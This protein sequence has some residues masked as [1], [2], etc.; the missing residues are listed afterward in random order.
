MDKYHTLMLIIFT[1]VHI[2]VATASTDLS[3][4]DIHRVGDD[5]SISVMNNGSNT[6]ARLTVYAVAE[7]NALVESLHPYPAE[8]VYHCNETWNITHPG[9][10]R[11]R[12]HFSEIEVY[13][14]AGERDRLII[15]DGDHGLVCAYPPM[16]IRLGPYKPYHASDV[17][18]PWIAGDMVRVVLNITGDR[19]QFKTYGFHIDEYD[20]YE[21][22]VPIYDEDID[23]G[24]HESKNT[25]FPADRDYVVAIIDEANSINETNETNNELTRKLSPEIAEIEFDP[26]VPMIGD[27]VTISAGVRNPGTDATTEVLLRIDDADV[28]NT[29]LS[30][31]HNETGTAVFYWTATVGCHN[32]T[33]VT[34][35][36]ELDGGLCVYHSDLSVTDLTIEPEDPLVMGD[37]VTITTDGVGD[38]LV[39]D[40]GTVPYHLTYETSMPSSASHCWTLRHPGADR[41]RLHFSHLELLGDTRL[42]I[43]NGTYTESYGYYDAY[44]NNFTDIRTPE[45][46]GDTLYIYLDTTHFA[47]LTIDKYEYR[48]NEPLPS[49]WSVYP[50]GP[51]NITAVVNE[52]KSI[53][54][55]DFTNNRMSK[56][57][58]VE[59]GDLSI[60]RIDT[61]PTGSMRDG[62]PV[63]IDVTVINIGVLPVTSEVTFLVDNT[64]IDLR[65]MTLA[66]GESTTITT[67][68]T[69]VANTHEIRVVADADDNVSETNE[70]N[71][72]HI[73]I[74]EVAGADFSVPA[75][76]ADPETISA[77][78]RNTGAASD[79]RIDVYDCT[80]KETYNSSDLGL[81]GDQMK[82]VSYIGV[83]CV[84]VNLSCVETTLEV[85]GS[86]GTVKISEP[87]WVVMPGDTISLYGYV[88]SDHP[89]HADFY[90][91]PVIAPPFEKTI[92]RNESRDISANWTPVAGRHVAVVY[93]DPGHVVCETDEENNFGVAYVYIEPTVDFAV[94]TP[95]ISPEHLVDS[96][97]ADITV[98]LNGTA[99]GSLLFTMED[100]ITKN[101]TEGWYGKSLTIAHE[102]DAIRVHFKNLSTPTSTYLNITDAS[103]NLL[104]S[105]TYD[106][107]LLPGSWSSWIYAETINI[108]KV[109]DFPIVADIDRYEC[110]NILRDMT[111]PVMANVTG[112]ITA[113]WQASTGDHRIH[114]EIASGVEEIDATNNC[115]DKLVSVKPS[116]DPTVLNITYGPL[117]PEN[118]DVVLIN[119]EIANIGFRH[120]DHAVEIWDTAERNF[121]IEANDFFEWYNR[122]WRVPG[123]RTRTGIGA[124]MTGVH[125]ESIDTDVPG[126]HSLHVYDDDGVEIADFSHCKRNDLWVW[127]KGDFLTVG[128][129]CENDT[130][131]EGFR[132]DR[133]A[134]RKLL[135]RTTALLDSGEI[136]TV[137]AM[138]NATT[139]WHTVE[140]IIDPEDRIDE[141][142]ESNNVLCKS[143]WVRGPDITPAS[144]RSEGGKISAVIRNIGDAGA[145]NVTVSFC[146]EVNYSYSH[147][148]FN[149]PVTERI[150]HTDTTKIRVRFKDMKIYGNM[151]IKDK[152]G[153]IVDE[154]SGE[155]SDIWTEWVHGD[156]VEIN[157]DVC[158]EFGVP[159]SSFEIDRYEYEF[160]GEIIDLDAHNQ[161]KVALDVA[162]EYE[163]PHNLSVWVDV[164]DDILESDED[165][166]NKRV[167]VYVDLVA[168]GIRFVSPDRY[169]LCL[170]AE[171]FVI[172]GLIT[173]GGAEDTITVP[174][175]DFNV[176]LEIKHRHSNGTVGDAV[177]NMTEYVEEPFDAG[178]H[179]IR[180][181]FDPND[182][183]ET[184]GNYTVSLTVDSTGDVCE[185]SGLYPWGE[186][187]NAISVE[188]FVHNSSGYTGGG[189]LIN[190]AQGAVNGRVV[191]TVGDSRYGRK[192]NPGEVKTVK[193]A[194]VVPDCADSIKFARIFVYWFAYHWE[195]VHYVPDLADVDV[196]FNGHALKKAGNYSDNPGASLNDYGYGLYSYDV[197]D[198]AAIGE[199]DVA[200][201]K[202]N[203]VDVYATTGVHAIGLLV[204]YDDEKEPL[205]KYWV[206]EGADIMMAANDKYPTG[207]TDCITTASFKGVE[208]NDIENVNATL[209][210]ILGMHSAYSPD[211][212]FSNP[213][214]AYEFNDYPIGSVKGTSH[215]INVDHIG[216]PINF[217]K[218]DEWDIITDYLKCGDNIAGIHSKGNYMLVNNAFLR[219]IFPPDLVVT[220]LTAPESTV[221]GAHHSINATIRNNGRSDAHDFN[222]T[223]YIGKKQMV[224]IPHLDLPAGNATTLHLYNWTPKMLGYVYNLT[225]AADVLSG[226]DWIEV[227]TDNNAM[228]RHVLIEEGGFGNQT[229]PKGEGGGAEAT[230]GK[231]TE[232]VTG[233]VMQG[234]KEFLSLGGGGGA[235]MFS[236]TEWIMKG[237]VWSVLLLFVCLGYWVEGRSYGRASRGSQ[238]PY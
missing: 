207:L 114:A 181:E 163:E 111:I 203:N 127:G 185:S 91:G 70:T 157:A 176:T 106:D 56:E 50:A 126:G 128:F 100:H 146:R 162:C 98:A 233:R 63:E 44:I 204:A 151:Y 13:G 229:G 156:T 99:D 96:D 15:E 93:A 169:M 178:Q 16:R 155:I 226:E 222:V 74:V 5:L 119:A 76:T 231:F 92:G 75:I 78:I 82:T 183:F 228:T 22:G 210:T 3:V 133:Y 200:T 161:T 164:D 230:G 130:M 141:I 205:T 137:H 174:V 234:M 225:A 188:I 167:M 97:S 33:I 216:Y 194:G 65:E 72:E 193:Y 46:G 87:G 118:G 26:A 11:M 14:G 148:R 25:I 23:F 48:V 30:I 80:F 66:A 202:N 121:T 60:T 132:I 190:V 51:H 153:A 221:V 139:G 39:Y 158:D 43:S 223:L 102:S 208:R 84:C 175:S 38:I 219:L 57:I 52:N 20:V 110:K 136:A 199:T 4:C 140:A 45:I 170:D 227:D 29:T 131:P 218:N 180:F 232:E 224:R 77:T 12:I 94:T 90:A 109:G 112:E 37:P 27:A 184:G 120:V 166:N 67:T 236:L 73:T 68:W 42:T 85:T 105:H 189:D 116:R 171:K 32:I 143:V 149:D 55:L 101:L 173:N 217:Y 86:T 59:G 165:N 124:E 160:E 135:N 1:I 142:N 192:M 17:H 62:E 83:D 47:N 172:D 237:A 54:E 238:Q 89:V 129:R 215:W 211:D 117:E 24:D 64:R 123:V 186:D 49:N 206:N 88:D 81:I 53:P 212:L 209:L 6:T 122:S 40:R 36:D 195:S 147:K 31:A 201:V 197:T 182:K 187:N 113:T 104:F 58:L 7:N 79:A 154:Y 125:F 159:L 168:D 69:A 19:T 179:E 108:V 28:A 95:R 2:S 177:F 235:G 145:E 220:N 61:T 198:Y 214:D 144:I 196:T 103:G 21:S 107:R 18:T 152:D 191:Y 34:D 9:A 35:D 213:G 71:N 10:V 41:I 8:A 115:A 138:L 134:Y 150:N